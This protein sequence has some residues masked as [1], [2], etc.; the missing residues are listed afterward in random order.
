MLWL[1]VAVMCFPATS[2]AQLT[3]TDLLKRVKETYAGANQYQFV[4]RLVERRKGAET[5]GSDEIAVDKHGRVWFKA[6]GSAALAWSGGRE[7]GVL[8]SVADGRNV[9]VYLEQQKLYKRVEGA[10]DPRD[11]DSEDDSID[12][13]KSFLR[14]VMDG[15]F[16]RYSRFASM[17][18]RSKI[19]REESCTANGVRSECYVLEINAKTTSPQTVTGVYT[20]WI[21]KQRYLV[22]RDD[23]SLIDK[24]AGTYT[25][26]IRYDIARINIEIPERLFSFTPPKGAKEVSS[27]FPIS[28][29]ST[30]QAAGL[31]RGLRSEAPRISMRCAL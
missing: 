17:S 19:V 5:T 2:Y 8:I 14:K 27:F 31:G 4:T 22:L 13:P 11:T 7:A 15:R 25:N 28:H 26:S 16:L 21:D 6:V 20:L 18:N 12:N 30:N 3:P 10:L 24:V 9:W 1:L 29:L 23:F